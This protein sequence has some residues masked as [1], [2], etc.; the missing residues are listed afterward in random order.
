ML[1][2]L[3]G[4]WSALRGTPQLGHLWPYFE[5]GRDT[6][7][8]VARSTPRVLALLEILQARGRASGAELA[9][10]LGVDRRTV[11]RYVAALEELG[12]PVTAERGRDGAYSLMAGFK[13]PPLM[14]TND[15]A[16]A[17]SLGLLA[18]RSL[19]LSDAAAAAASAQAKLERA[20]P[21]DLKQRVRAVEGSVQ[22]DLR[23][24]IGEA[25]R[26]VVATLSTAARGRQRVLMTY[27]TP[28]GV[29][30][31]RAIDPYGLAYYLGRWYAVGMCH[32]R[33]DLRSF[34]LDRVQSVETLT[35]RFARPEGFDALEHMREAL[36]TVPRAHA[37]RVRLAT[38]LATAQRSIAP[39]LGVLT[40]ASESPSGG[41]LIHSQVDDLDWCARELSRLPFAFEVL[42]PEALGEALRMLARRL[43]RAASAHRAR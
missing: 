20:M 6:L 19:G 29:E 18:G 27:R 1:E 3:V 16:L 35:D 5:P 2:L 21:V 43:W 31:R 41:V 36:A 26:G 7:A 39:A 15:E 42:E 33:N 38:D 37:I 40:W 32:L 8:V 17:L 34:R 10:W 23:S 4:E 24:P 11:R 14:F 12:V 30:S 28:Q 9:A 13:L 22:L 25:D